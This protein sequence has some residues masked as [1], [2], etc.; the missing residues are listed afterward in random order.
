MSSSSSSSL[1][2]AGACLGAGTGGGSMLALAGAA[3]DASIHNSSSGV[4][5]RGGLGSDRD[6]DLFFSLF[7]PRSRS[8][9]RSLSRLVLRWRRL[10][11]SSRS[12]LRLFLSFFFL[13][14]SSSVELVEDIDDD[15]ERFLLFRCLLDPGSGDNG[16]AGSLG[17]EGQMFSV[18]RSLHSRRLYTQ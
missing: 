4:G 16:H 7:L 2:T 18:L 12:P 13:R 9:S 3:P 6:F 17:E 5:E 11:F 8:R 1:L 15:L 14:L 10:R